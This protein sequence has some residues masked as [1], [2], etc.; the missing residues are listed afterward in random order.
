M[1]ATTIAVSAAVAVICAAILVLLTDI[2]VTVTRWWS[3]GPLATTTEVQ[4][5]M[6]QQER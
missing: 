4:S 1:K 3:C 6:C 2:E 5:R